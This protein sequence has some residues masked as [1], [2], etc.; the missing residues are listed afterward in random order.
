[1]NKM[2]PSVKYLVIVFLNVRNIFEK[3]GEDRMF[4][5]RTVS[6]YKYIPMSKLTLGDAKR[7]SQN[8]TQI[9]QLTV[10]ANSLVVHNKIDYA[11][12]SIGRQYLDRSIARKSNPFC[13]A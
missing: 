4:R 1:M 13:K 12:M 8:H 10:T 3:Y 7:V 5:I 2:S 9:A 11:S 6:V